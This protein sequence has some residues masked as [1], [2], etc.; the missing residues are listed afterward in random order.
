MNP[1]RALVVNAMRHRLSVACV[2]AAMTA[3]TAAPWVLAQQPR[4]RAAE[5]RTLQPLASGWRFVQDDAM[6]DEAALASTGERL[7]GRDPAAHLER[8]RRGEHQRDA[9]PT[10][11]GAAGIGSSSTRRDVAPVTGCSSTVRASSPTCG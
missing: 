6:T 7:A 5:P 10:S 4:I 3:V 8:Q 2:I 1:A 11:A 9:C